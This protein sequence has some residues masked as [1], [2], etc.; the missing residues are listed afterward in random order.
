MRPS[1][2]NETRNIFLPFL[3]NDQVGNM[4]PTMQPQTAVTLSPSSL[5]YSRNAS[6]TAAGHSAT[7]GHPASRGTL[8]VVPTMDSDHIT[9]PAPV[10]T[11]FSQKAAAIA[12]VS[13]QNSGSRLL[14]NRCPASC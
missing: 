14:R 6:R 1:S 10:A 4:V 2:I 3:Y 9:R 13:E 11:R 7:A 5:V 12:Q 8:F